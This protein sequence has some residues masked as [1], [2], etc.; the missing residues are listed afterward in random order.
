MRAVH[1]TLKDIQRRL[2]V[3]LQR[4]ITVS[5]MASIGKVK[6]RTVGDWLRGT[7][8]QPGMEALMHW[9]S[10]L[11]EH[12]AKEVLASWRSKDLEQKPKRRGE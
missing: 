11:P 1:E 10:N 2:S 9:L 7:T 5:D 3:A 4:R 8:P 12:E 6:G